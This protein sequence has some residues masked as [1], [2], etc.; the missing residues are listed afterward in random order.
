[1]SLARSGWKTSLISGLMLGA[2]A[3]TDLFVGMNALLWFA[4]VNVRPFFRERETR[5]RIAF[6]SLVALVVIFGGFVLELFPART[7][8][9]TLGLHRMAKIAPIYLLVELGPLFVLGSAGLYLSLRGGRYTD[10]RSVFPL[11]LMSLI[12]AFV[13]VVPYELNIV[14]RK[15][16]KVVQLPL[17]VFTAVACDALLRLPARH[18]MRVT[19]A[20]LIFLGFS[21]LGTDLYQYVDLETA[22]F[23]DTTYYSQDKM[24]ALD[25]IRSNTPA[26][27]IVQLLDQVRPERKAKEDYDISIPAVAERGT[28]IGNYEFLHVM[29]LDEHITDQRKAILEHVFTATEPGVLQDLLG[30]LPAHYILVDEDSP[31]PL[32]AIRQLRDSG[33]LEEIFRSGKMSVLRK[34]SDA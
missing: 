31:G 24:R 15:S 18:W 5:Y 32:A 2:V 9:L 28:L 10:F 26:D 34:R 3:V 29:H 4:V 1:M 33:Y 21:T 23:P 6:A 20:A 8:E 7:G 30:R 25:W 16:I 14:I 11:L 13:V 12:V 19:G 27:T 22:R 17:L